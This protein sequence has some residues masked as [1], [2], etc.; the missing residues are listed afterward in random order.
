MKTMFGFSAAKAEAAK[1]RKRAINEAFMTGS[2]PE[3]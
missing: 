1:V 2:E 3:S